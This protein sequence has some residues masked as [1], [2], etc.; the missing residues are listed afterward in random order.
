MDYRALSD[1]V[2][3]LRYRPGWTFTLV[4]ADADIASLGLAT[5]ESQSGTCIYWPLPDVEVVLFISL[6]TLDANHPENELTI[7]HQFDVPSKGKWVWERWLFDRIMDVE[8]HE[9]M[10]F[11]EVNGVRPYYPD[12]T[13]PAEYRQQNL[14]T[15]ERR[16]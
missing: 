11:Y 15:I 9:A 12:H 4:T 8:L 5:A 16:R 1:A 10:E 2:Q 14:Y 7:L 3:S 13:K 6:K